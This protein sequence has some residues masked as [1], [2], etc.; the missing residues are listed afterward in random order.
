MAVLQERSKPGRVK[1][2]K[3]VRAK[4]EQELPRLAHFCSVHTTNRRISLRFLH[5]RCEWCGPQ[6]RRAVPRSHSL[7]C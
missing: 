1:F 3:R 7:E 5:L 2:P 4:R 6:A